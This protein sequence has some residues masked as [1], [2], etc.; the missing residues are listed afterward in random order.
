VSASGTLTQRPLASASCSTDRWRPRRRFPLPLR[1]RRILLIREV[2]PVVLLEFAAFAAA[3]G[4]KRL[5]AD[6]E[7]KDTAYLLRFAG[8]PQ[9]LATP[10]SYFDRLITPTQT[11]F[12]RSHH[13]PP[14]LDR[15][16]KLSIAGLVKTPLEL[17]V[18][19]LNKQFTEVTITAVMQCAGNG[20]AFMSPRV[21]GIQWQHGAMAQAA[22]TGVRLK[23]VLEKAGLDEAGA[24]VRISGADTPAKP[25]TPQFVRSIP[26]DRALDPSTL[27]A[28][29][30]N[31]EDLTLAHGAPMRLVVPRWAGD[32]WVKWLTGV[33]VQ[34]EESRTSGV[35]TPESHAFPGRG[36][37][38]LPEV[39]RQEL[40]IF[41]FLNSS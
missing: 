37:T 15:S 20:R 11:F 13:G 21:P 39:K 26:I 25:A 35:G 17:S 14:A 6:G 12:V 36:G 1:D 27:I 38:R 2:L 23:D 10:T 33:K 29:K 7:T 24:H 3:P 4:P 19:E 9:N 22:F 32:H 8:A 18:E 30:M 16:R 5:L 34:K 40:S 31:G 28:Y 41:A